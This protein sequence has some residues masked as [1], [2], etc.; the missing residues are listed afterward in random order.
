MAIKLNVEKNVP[1]PSTKLKELMDELCKLNEGDSVYLEYSDFTKTVIVNCM[2]NLRIR[3]AARGLTVKTIGDV[4]GKR[5][6]IL[7]IRGIVN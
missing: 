3:M 1:I 6:W 5:I 2:A 4:N 7:K